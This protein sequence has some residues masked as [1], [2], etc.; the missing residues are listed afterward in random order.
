M[1]VQTSEQCVCVCVCVCKLLKLLVYYVSFVVS[2]TALWILKYTICVIVY[3]DVVNVQPHFNF[4]DEIITLNLESSSYYNLSLASL[5][6]YPF[7]FSSPCSM[8][9]RPP[10]MH[11]LSV[12]LYVWSFW[13]YYTFQNL[14]HLHIYVYNTKIALCS[15]VAHMYKN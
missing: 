12:E 1:S 2:I 14:F 8:E 5:I 10:N 11:T 3:C 4:S 13:S 9:N 6:H 7:H 15:S